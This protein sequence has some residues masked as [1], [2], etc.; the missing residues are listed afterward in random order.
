MVRVRFAPSPTGDIHIGNVRAAVFN[1][2]FAKKNNGK[3]ILRIEDTD[4]ERSSVE[5][6]HRI[7]EDLKWL[8]LDFD[9]GP[10]KEGDVG[11]Y[12]QSE[13]LDIYKKY[14]DNLLGNGFAYRCFCK[15]L[16]DDD[17]DRESE[18]NKAELCNCQHFDEDEVELFLNDKIPYAIRIHVNKKKVAVNDLVFG[19]IEKEVEDFVIMKPNGYP[20]YHFGVVLDD[21]LMNITHVIRGQDHLNNTA[22]H[23]YLYNLLGFKPPK[24][25]HYSLTFG[26][27][28]RDKSQS[29]RFLREQG[30]LPEAVLNIALL[31]GWYP[32]DGK[33]YFYFKDKIDEFKISDFSKANANFDRE[34]FNF[35][36]KQHIK[37]KDSNDLVDLAIPFLKKANIIDDNYDREKV[38][39]II[40]AVKSNIKCLSE[41]PEQIKFLTGDSFEIGDKEKKV[42]DEENSRLVLKSLLEK[43]NAINGN[44]FSFQK[45]IKEVQEDTKVKGKALYMPARIAI[46]GQMHGPEMHYVI[47]IVGKEKIIERIQN[48][49]GA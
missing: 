12:R 35:L 13:R 33:E 48:I 24:F 2:L 42:L 17:D 39:I 3:F 38:K 43:L 34:K 41:I 7:I 5:S 30:Y 28:K 14:A 23:I 1:Y 44:D 20:T 29:I 27:S 22:K 18:N 6:E 25:A 8:G 40:E 32:K 21:H 46:T 15:A 4:L 10:G 31:L 11:P 9:E 37:N 16:S 49:I 19:K 26:L 45:I 47:S 36:A